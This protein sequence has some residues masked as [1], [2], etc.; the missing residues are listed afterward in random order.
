LCCVV[1]RC[2]VLCCVVLCCVVYNTWGWMAPQEVRV[3]EIRDLLHTVNRPLL[4]KLHGF[5][6]VKEIEVLIRDAKS[7][8]PH[9]S[10]SSHSADG[11]T[12]QQKQASN[13][14][15][16]EEGRQQAGLDKE[17]G[18]GAGGEERT[19]RVYQGMILVE[20]LCALLR[21]KRFY[22]RHPV[23]GVL[24]PTHCHDAAGNAAAAAAAAAAGVEEG[25]GRSSSDRFG[26]DD[27]GG[28]GGSGDDG[29]TREADEYTS[30]SSDN[31]DEADFEADD[32]LELMEMQPLHPH[33]D[34]GNGGGGGGGSA[35]G[36]GGPPESPARVFARKT[37]A[38]LNKRA[39]A[40][41]MIVEQALLRLDAADLDLWLDIGEA[42]NKAAYHVLAD[43]PAHK[44]HRLFRTM[45]LRHLVVTDELNEVHGIITR[46]DLIHHQH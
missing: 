24:E 1:L 29:G 15:D 6:V 37:L 18:G 20:G 17:G 19:L 31:E 42:M 43:T 30:I 23:S 7:T 12:H 34:S 4:N 39:D 25:D 11:G 10:P 35:A 33:S 45:G 46:A 38:A 27:D 40:G 8:T 3:R 44:V 36:G 5:P 9:P 28:S 13:G 16:E 32:A 41:E 26:L 2:V 22:R 14:L 21:S